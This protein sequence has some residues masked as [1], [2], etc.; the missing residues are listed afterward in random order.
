[1]AAAAANFEKPQGPRRLPMVIEI[2]E[3]TNLNFISMTVIFK[4]T[5]SQDSLISCSELLKRK[6]EHFD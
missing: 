5:I 6:M 3:D 2:F 4:F 1:L